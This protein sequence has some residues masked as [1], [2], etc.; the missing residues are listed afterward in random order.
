MNKYVKIDKERIIKHNME[1]TSE[2]CLTLGTAL[3]CVTRTITLLYTF[4]QVHTN[5]ILNPA[6]AHS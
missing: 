4:I 5:G 1:D 6:S 2:G 3:S